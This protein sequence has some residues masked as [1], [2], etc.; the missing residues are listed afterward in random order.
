MDNKQFERMV[1]EAHAEEKAVMAVKGADYAEGM[2]EMEEDRLANF[3]LVNILLAGAPMDQTTACAVYLIK[4]IAAVCKAVRERKL[5]SEPLKGRLVDLRNYVLL[6]EANFHETN[7]DLVDL[8]GSR[9]ALAGFETLASALPHNQAQEEELSHTP[10]PTDTK[11]KAERAARLITEVWSE[12][13]EQAR[14]D[15]ARRHPEAGPQ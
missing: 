14:A 1:D 6:L 5:A 4:H 8:D 10:E 12:L 11:T 7:P 15:D 2:G 13:E 3:K 9:A